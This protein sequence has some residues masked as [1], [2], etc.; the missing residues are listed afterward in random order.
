MPH[1]LSFDHLF[2]YDSPEKG[3]NLKIRLQVDE[4]FKTEE[5]ETKVDTG[6]SHCVFKRE[7]GEKLGL[8]IE[9]GLR[10]SIGTA[11]SP[12]V[13]YGHEVNLLIEQYVVDTMVYFAADQ[14]PRNV[15]GQHGFLERFCIAVVHYDQKMYLSEYNDFVSSQK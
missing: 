14:I 15:L 11:T 4:N 6:S 9:N 1:L 8:N 7:Y 13:A 10:L 5:I 12:F 2:S 3:I